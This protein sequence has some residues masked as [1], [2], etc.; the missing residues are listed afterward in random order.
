[1]ENTPNN[2]FPWEPYPSDEVKKRQKPEKRCSVTLLVSLLCIVIA[3]TMLL[4]YTLTSEYVRSRY[5]DQIEAQQS[6]VDALERDKARLNAT[7][8]QLQDSIAM[9]EQT[10]ADGEGS[11]Y[12]KLE[13]LSLLFEY[14]SYYADSINEEEILDT[15]LK[16]YAQ[17]TGDRY[18]EYYTQ[19]EYESLL[20][21]NAGSSVGIGVSVVQTDLAVSGVTYQVYQVI[22]IYK[23]APAE[24]SELRLG[25]YI[26]A[27]K[28][29]G[30]YQSITEIGY[31]A[32]LNAI[33]GEAG[34]QAE[35]LTF[36]ADGAEYL[37]MEIAIT[38]AEFVK[39]S[40]SYKISQADP[41]VGI[42]HLMEFDMTTPTQFKQAVSALQAAGVQKFVFDV[43]N[44]PGGDLQS[45]KAVLSFFLEDG[46]LI[47]SAIDKNGVAAQSYYAET[48]TFAGMYASCSVSEAELGM[49]RDLDMV[50]LCN[51]NTASAAEVFTSSLR[52]LKNT[53]VIGVK[54][55]GKGIMQS[56]LNLA[57][58]SYGAYDGWVKMTTYAYVTASGVPYH[59]IGLVPD[60][61]VALSE[62]AKTYNI[63]VL[64][65]ELDDQLLSAIAEVN[66]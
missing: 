27:V 52:D 22:S 3:I 61:E 46:D 35:L 14:Y 16:A 43:R 4:T 29:D 13:F 12:D 26:Y 36:R 63:Y 54:T 47:L 40:V 33:R 44:N 24:K 28:I 11:E 18:A 5:I 38:R 9:L 51:E 25:D 65:E 6:N 30:E 20:Q 59:D 21:D 8:A 62:E 49:Y 50:V 34:S 19:E 10:I 56:Y 64:P 39:Q 31:T 55:F 66:R 15:V 57:Y 37:S 42:V 58:Y 7:I 2:G 32:A 45:I 41:T 60:V 48:Q 23:N 1:M 17:A 53:P